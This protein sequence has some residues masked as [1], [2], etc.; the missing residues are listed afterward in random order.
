MLMGWDVS[1]LQPLTGL[2]FIPKLIHEYGESWWNDIDRGN[3]ISPRK[4]CPSATSST[5][6]HIWTDLGANLGLHREKPA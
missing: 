6:N 1:E 5:T 3:Q 4:T 2:L